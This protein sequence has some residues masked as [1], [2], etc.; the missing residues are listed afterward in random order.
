[1]YLCP[2]GKKYLF[3]KRWKKWEDLFLNCFMLGKV[4]NQ[5]IT[6]I[7]DS[8]SI[9][10]LNRSLILVTPQSLSFTLHKK[11]SIFF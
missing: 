11:H 8:P 7:W 1:M 9:P 3:S 2:L 6:K 5:G 4:E 10:T